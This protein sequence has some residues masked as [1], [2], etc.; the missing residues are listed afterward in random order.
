[1]GTLSYHAIGVSQLVHAEPGETSERRSGRRA[2]TTFRK[3]PTAR[4]GQNAIA[5]IAAV[6]A[7]SPRP[8]Q[9]VPSETG[10]ASTSPFSRPRRDQLPHG[11]VTAGN[12]ARRSAGTSGSAGAARGSGS[13]LPA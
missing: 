11:L 7:P 3:L 1:S 13:S 2:A 5:A 8:P 9:S 12:R 4:P 10:A 6:I